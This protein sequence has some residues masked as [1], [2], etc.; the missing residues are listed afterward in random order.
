MLRWRFWTIAVLLSVGCADDPETPSLVASS[1]SEQQAL[2]SA[3]VTTIDFE[4]FRRRQHGRILGLKSPGCFDGLEWAH[5]TKKKTLWWGNWAP[6]DESVW[7]PG[8]PR[9]ISGAGGSDNWLKGRA[10]TIGRGAQISRAD[11]FVF[12]SMRLYTRRSPLYL[13]KVT[14][15]WEDMAGLKGEPKRI[16]LQKNDWLKVTAKEIGAEGR[17]LK[18]LWF[19]GRRANAYGSV[20]GLDDLVLEIAST[21]CDEGGDL[22]P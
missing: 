6:Q 9:G 2:A 3:P 22:C 10:S 4:S 5:N 1:S 18:A 16:R 20:F 19:N 14:V 21:S 15:S 12:R 7:Q 8:A 17:T 11:G 13:D